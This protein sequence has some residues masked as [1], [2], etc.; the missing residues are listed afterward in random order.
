MVSLGASTTV[1]PTNSR[2]LWILGRRHSSRLSKPRQGF[3]NMSVLM[4]EALLSRN[5]E[6]VPIAKKVDDLGYSSKRINLNAS[7]SGFDALRW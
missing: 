6:V 5:A 2:V 4:G 3:L 1:R 7:K